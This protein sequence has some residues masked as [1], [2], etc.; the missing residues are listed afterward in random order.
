MSERQILVGQVYRHYKKNTLY[1]IVGTAT[2]T[3]TEEELA[4]YRDLQND[5]LFARPSE[6]FLEE[7]LFNGLLVQRFKLE[8]NHGNSSK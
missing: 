8:D 5:R 2:H 1:E 4:I 3:E 7:V 6:I